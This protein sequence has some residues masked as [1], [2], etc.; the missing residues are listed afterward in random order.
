VGSKC[1]DLVIVATGMFEV[2]T[3]RGGQ[4]GSKT[5]LKAHCRDHAVAHETP[6]S[7]CEVLSPIY[8]PMVIPPRDWTTP[9]DG[10]YLS[11]AVKRTPW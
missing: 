9:F 6:D 8:L 11:N 10:G 4:P 5:V 2:I 3:Y 1:L 7:R